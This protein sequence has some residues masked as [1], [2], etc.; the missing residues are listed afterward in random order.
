[1]SRVVTEARAPQCGHRD[2]R[3]ARAAAGPRVHDTATR[4]LN[5][6]GSPL[7]DDHNNETSGTSD[8]ARDC[9]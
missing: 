4:W 8:D 5:T 7:H 3:H 6:C 9:I 1:M 2:A